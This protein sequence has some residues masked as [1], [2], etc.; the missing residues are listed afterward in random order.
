MNKRKILILCKYIPSSLNM[1]KFLCEQYD[2]TSTKEF[3]D[4]WKQTDE[5]N[6][7]DYED[8]SYLFEKAVFANDIANEMK[9]MNSFVNQVIILGEYEES[10]K[11]YI[12]QYAIEMLNEYSEDVDWYIQFMKGLPTEYYR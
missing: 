11:A 8:C 2:K 12:K 7:I 5:G 3:F 10:E 6:I 1:A 9:N 4:I